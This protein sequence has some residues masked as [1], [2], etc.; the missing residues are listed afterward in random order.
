MSILGETNRF[1]LL[2]SSK[3]I[4]RHRDKRYR[5]KNCKVFFAIHIFTKFVIGEDRT[6]RATL[7]SGC[8]CRGDN[9]RLTLTVFSPKFA[10]RHQGRCHALPRELPCANKGSAMRHRGKCHAPPREVPRAN[11]GGHLQRSH[12]VQ[13]AIFNA[14]FGSFNLIYSNPSLNV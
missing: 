14:S 4:Y 1:F 3:L 10:M 6:K 7:T 8:E 11:E 9:L 2:S 13:Q 5:R 12:E